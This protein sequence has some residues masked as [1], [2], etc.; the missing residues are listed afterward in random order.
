MLVGGVHPEGPP[1][2]LTVLTDVP[3]PPIPPPTATQFEGDAQETAARNNASTF[4]SIVVQVDP[5]CVPITAGIE[6]TV[7]TATQVLAAGHDT[8]FSE[9]KPEGGT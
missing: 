3:P 6:L 1:H 9:V 2:A 8:L 4:G 5:S 7:P